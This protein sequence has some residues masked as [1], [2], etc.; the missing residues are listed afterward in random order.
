MA[1]LGYA[2]GQNVIYEY[3]YA[4]GYGDRWDELAAD[5]IRLPVDLIF[6]ATTPAA[7]AARRATNTI[8][9]VLPTGDL[10]GAGLA[11]SLAHPGG[12]VTGLSNISVQLSG[13]RLE[14]LKG[15]IPDLSRVAMFWQP[16]N[17]T[18]ARDWQES[19]AAAAI[20]SVVLQSVELRPPI[21]FDGAFM[22]A[23]EG[24]AQ[25]VLVRGTTMA[26]TEH[27]RFAEVARRSRL[28]IMG[29][30]R[31]LVTD[32]ALM[33]Y[34]PSVNQQYRRA[35]YY[36]DR[37]FKGASPADLPIEQPMTFDFVVNMKTAQALGITFPNEI[38]LQVTDVIQ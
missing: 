19:Q 6:T 17:A 24:R 7:L 5:L 36:V 16:D 38:M 33:A 15:T 28:P 3:R 35:A 22:A 9:I 21:D 34:G 8:P 29:D 2:E 18:E 20:L 10:V 14:L 12:N 1:D 37:I 23:V 30:R 31:A 32:G 11:E 4:E 27:A 26:N 25:A 13:K